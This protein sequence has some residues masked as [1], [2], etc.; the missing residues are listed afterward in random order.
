MADISIA[1]LTSVLQKG[2]LGTDP[3]GYYL[4][5]SEDGTCEVRRPSI[6]ELTETVRLLYPDPAAE[7]SA[8]HEDDL[9]DD[10]RRIMEGVSRA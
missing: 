5:I 1:D 3:N 8:C 10:G 7:L 6:L 4:W 9:V 2:T